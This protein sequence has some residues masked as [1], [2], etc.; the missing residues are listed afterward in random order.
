M[1]E[2]FVIERGVLNVTFCI[3]TLL[4][5]IVVKKWALWTVTGK[6]C[7]IRCCQTLSVLWWTDICVSAFVGPKTV[8]H[9]LG[10]QHISCIW[11]SIVLL[12]NLKWNWF[13]V[14][15]RLPYRE[16]RTLTVSVIQIN[17]SCVEFSTSLCTFGLEQWTGWVRT[18][19]WCVLFSCL[20]PA[21]WFIIYCVSLLSVWAK[22]HVY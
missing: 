13:S 4:D 20:C 3:L 12:R 1:W 14:C 8:F 2:K 6:K 9:C 5:F 15:K 16:V 19:Y 22:W 7:W 18:E 10:V 17:R 11:N 21:C